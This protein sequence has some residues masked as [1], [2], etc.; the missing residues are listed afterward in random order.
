M[1]IYSGGVIMFDGSVMDETRL[2]SFASKE[3]N[4]NTVTSAFHEYT[5]RHE[6]GNFGE[7]FRGGSGK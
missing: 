3:R 2:V 7:Y 4:Y 5:A 6:N 1:C